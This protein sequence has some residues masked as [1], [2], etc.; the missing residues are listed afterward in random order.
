[1]VLSPNGISDSTILSCTIQ[2]VYY[3]K[4]TIQQE[5]IIIKVENA[6]YLYY[7]FVIPY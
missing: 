3:I 4:T 6:L 2:E 1:M 5:D 7:F